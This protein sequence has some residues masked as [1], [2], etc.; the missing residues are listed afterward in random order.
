MVLAKDTT[1][2]LE[3]V[4]LADQVGSNSIL[5]MS[6]ANSSFYFSGS[7]SYIYIYLY[8]L[9]HSHGRCIKTTGLTVVI[10]V[11]VISSVISPLA[12][13]PSIVQQLQQHVEDVRMSFFHLAETICWSRWNGTCFDPLWTNEENMEFQICLV[14][15]HFFRLR[16][17]RRN[18]I[19]GYHLQ[20]F[21][22]CINNQPSQSTIHSLL[23]GCITLYHSKHGCI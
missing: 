2:P 18:P 16:N 20:Q 6:Y 4:S 5:C 14:I 10:E 22:D 19:I 21:Q 12:P 8:H 9:Y 1:R 13:G 23:A 11:P 17:R 15:L 3:S 7:I